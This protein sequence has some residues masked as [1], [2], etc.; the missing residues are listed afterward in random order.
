[1]KHNWKPRE[2]IM[3]PP[4]EKLIMYA[5]VEKYVKDECNKKKELE[6]K[7]KQAKAKR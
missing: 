6:S 1:M 3:L 5:F 2:F 7:V 4:K